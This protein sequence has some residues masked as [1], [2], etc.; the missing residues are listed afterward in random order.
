MTALELNDRSHVDVL[1]EHGWLTVGINDVVAAD[2]Y[3]QIVLKRC[4]LLL[5]ALSDDDCL[6]LSE[7]LTPT[8]SRKRWGD[9]LVSP[10]KKAVRTHSPAVAEPQ[11]SP[12]IGAATNTSTTSLIPSSPIPSS[13]P[14]LT[15]TT[16]ISSSAPNPVTTNGIVNAYN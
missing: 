9:N 10:V 15:V 13:A 14:D 2:R 12:S 8:S 1:S 6:G 5:Q 16:P 4:L 11:A 7:Y 3:G